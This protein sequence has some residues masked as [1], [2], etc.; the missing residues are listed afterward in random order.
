VCPRPTPLPPALFVS[1]GGGT[2]FADEP[3]SVPV[4]DGD[5]DADFVNDPDGDGAV[6]LDA[7]GDDDRLGD[8][9]FVLLVVALVDPGDGLG[10]EPLPERTDGGV[11]GCVGAP[12]AGPSDGCGRF[13]TGSMWNGVRVLTTLDTSRCA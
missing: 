10:D 11:C 3:D 1:S 6:E 9:L 12:D 4:G 13:R 8:P 7:G 5:F 2:P